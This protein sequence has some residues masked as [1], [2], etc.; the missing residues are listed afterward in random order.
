MGH[1]LFRKVGKRGG[2]ELPTVFYG[3]DGKV[4]RRE[5][6]YP[7]ELR[8]ILKG[9]VKR[10]QDIEVVVAGPFRFVRNKA[11]DFIEDA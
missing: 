8:V 5:P 1:I 6:L 7:N 9:W 4:L 2:E 11:G 3:H 10:D